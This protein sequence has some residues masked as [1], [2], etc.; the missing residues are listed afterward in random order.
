MTYTVFGNVQYSPAWTYRQ[1]QFALHAFDA[2]GAAP[3]D[4]P[5]LMSVSS[6]G[7][8][9]YYQTTMQSLDGQMG[10]YMTEQEASGQEQLILSKVASE[11][12]QY[13]S[14]GVHDPT[15]A[16]ALVA[17]I[18]AAYEQ[19][20]GMDPN[21]PILQDLAA[22]H[23]NVMATGPG[24]FTNPD[25][26]ALDTYIGPGPHGYANGRTDEDGTIGSDEIQ[27]YVSA[28]Q[29]MANKLNESSQLGML[30]LNNI[31]DMLKMVTSLATNLMSVLDEIPQ[32]IADTI[33]RT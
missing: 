22:L 27:S 17:D 10:P 25:T 6:S 1:D 16:A 14:D 13:Q 28:L 9:A 3:L 2:A 24:Q 8:L 26:G 15:K 33:G 4:A 31:A 11:L 20:K 29:S 5:G 18:R 30:H 21:S 19:I 7:L 32:K 23:D 12:Q